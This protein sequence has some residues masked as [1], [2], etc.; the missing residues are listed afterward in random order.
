MQGTDEARLNLNLDVRNGGKI[1]FDDEIDGGKAVSNQIEYDGYA[2][3]INITPA[4]FVRNARRTAS[5]STAGSTTFTI[6]RLTPLRWYSG[7]TLP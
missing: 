1:V 4:T 6:L 3:D 5:F 2:Y 7:K